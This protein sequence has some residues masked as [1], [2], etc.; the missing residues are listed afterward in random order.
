MNQTIK[1]IAFAAMLLVGGSYVKAEDIL[2]WQVD[3]STLVDGIAISTWLMASPYVSDSMDDYFAARVKTIQGA[4]SRILDFWYD[5]PDDPPK[6]WEDGSWGISVAD[7]DGAVYNM[8]EVHGTG[9]VQSG[10][11]YKTWHSTTDDPASS[12]DDIAALDVRVVMELG[13][14]S[15]SDGAND[16]VWQTIAASDPELYS[17][18]R[19]LHMYGQGTIGPWSA[20]P[21]QPNL[22]TNPNVPEPDSFVLVL[23]GLGL[24]MLLRK[25]ERK[26]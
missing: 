24:L 17:E 5:N 10:T 22:F 7:A 11:G 4:S 14:N 25:T 21:W 9:E 19:N 18:L 20:T 2:F 26:E 16:Y 6:R 12:L 13:Y 23:L 15:W 8:G 3:E 1:K